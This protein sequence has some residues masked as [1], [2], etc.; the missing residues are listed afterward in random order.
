MTI[1]KEIEIEV[2]YFSKY[3][4]VYFHKGSGPEMTCF[5]SVQFYKKKNVL[6]AIMLFNCTYRLI[7]LCSVSSLVSSLLFVLYVSK[8]QQTSLIC[9]LV[10]FPLR[11]FIPSLTCDSFLGTPCVFREGKVMEK[12]SLLSIK[13]LTSLCPW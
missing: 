13:H 5:T 6:Q 8:G 1:K 3:A 11:V 12:L 2:F 7:F 9:L 10:I 4:Q